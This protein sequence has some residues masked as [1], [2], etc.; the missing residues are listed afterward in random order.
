[1]L[2]PDAHRGDGPG[3]I[4]NGRGCSHRAQA[5]DAPTYQA[6][7]PED[8]QNGRND[9][10]RAGGEE[11]LAFSPDSKGIR[12]HSKA[13]RFAQRKELFPEGHAVLEITYGVVACK[14]L[15]NGRGGQQPLGKRLF[16]GTRAGRAH[17][18]EQRRFAEQV[19]V[20]GIRMR[21]IEEAITGLSGS[22]QRSSSLANPRS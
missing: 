19:E 10:S 18:L 6:C 16:A 21:W 20:A 8:G 5:P 15:R 4:Q 1:M 2:R 9:A 14:N 12:L 22:G 13:H 7:N 17:Q 3:Q 11:W